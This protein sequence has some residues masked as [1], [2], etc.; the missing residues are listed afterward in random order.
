MD[1][2]APDR[3]AEELVRS[4]VML[5]IAGAAEVK[6]VPRIELVEEFLVDCLAGSCQG[7]IQL[8]EANH[9]DLVAGAV[10]VTLLRG[11]ED[12]Y[13]GKVHVLPEVMVVHLGSDLLR[14]LH[15]RERLDSGRLV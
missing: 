7:Q 10:A 11:R 4:Q 1:L 3:D 15:E 8:L 5:H 12:L 13:V 6:L 9:R 2:E 14:E